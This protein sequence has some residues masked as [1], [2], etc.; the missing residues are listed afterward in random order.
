VREKLTSASR[1]SASEHRHRDAG[2]PQATC[3]GVVSIKSD[4]MMVK[5]SALAGDQQ[6]DEI[7]LRTARP[8]A[9]DDM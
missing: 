5:G 2:A 1:T 4:D 8:Q 3:E 6:V 7:V 9:I